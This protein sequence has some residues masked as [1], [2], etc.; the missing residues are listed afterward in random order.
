VHFVGL[1]FSS[2][3]KATAIA[4]A[5]ATTAQFLKLFWHSLQ[6][7]RVF[8]LSTPKT[9]SVPLTCTLI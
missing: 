7:L 1:F 8:M 4:T 9:N 3:I 6:Q 2:R 5:T